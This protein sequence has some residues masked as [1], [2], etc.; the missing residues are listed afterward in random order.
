MRSFWYFLGESI[1]KKIQFEIDIPSLFTAYVEI[2][3]TCS[4]KNH[5]ASVMAGGDEDAAT[6]SENVK[7]YLDWDELRIGLR[8]GQVV[9]S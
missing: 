6:W 9:R 3:Y 8:P 2:K 5:L 7:V 1:F 4:G